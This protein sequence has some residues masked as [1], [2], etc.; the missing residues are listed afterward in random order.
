MLVTGVLAW[1]IGALAFLPILADAYQSADFSQRMATIAA[2][3]GAWLGQNLLFLVGTVATAAGLSLLV[4]PLHHRGLI[5]PAQLGRIAIVAAALLWTIIIYFLLAIPAEDVHA[6]A[7]LPV[8]YE[9]ID[10]W[11]WRLASGLTL[12]S[13]IAYGVAFLGSG[14][15]RWVGASTVAASAAMLAG[16]IVVGNTTPPLLFFL[17]PF[18]IGAVL[19]R[20]GPRLLGRNRPVPAT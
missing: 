2:H 12:G 10:T 1:W 3:R 7:Q 13:F 18:A 19:L 16:A 20:R 4:R 5:R 14:L 6:A 17:V 15:P 9:A 11:I 8:V